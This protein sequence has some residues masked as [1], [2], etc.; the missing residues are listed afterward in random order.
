VRG[1]V[2][3]LLPKPVSGAI[4]PGIAPGKVPKADPNPGAGEGLVVA[5]RTT[6]GFVPKRGPDMNLESGAGGGA[7]VLGSAF[8]MRLNVPGFI[9]G[10]NKLGALVVGFV[11]SSENPPKSSVGTGTLVTAGVGKEDEGLSLGAVLF[12]KG[13]GGVFGVAV[14]DE[15]GA[16][17]S[18]STKGSTLAGGGVNLASAGDGEVTLEAVSHCPNGIFGDAGRGLS[19]EPLTSSSSPPDTGVFARGELRSG[20]VLGLPR[21]VLE[22]GDGVSDGEGSVGIGCCNDNG[23][24]DGDPGGVVLRRRTVDGS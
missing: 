17:K 20:R 23:S 1:G 3:D 16:L 13:T 5:P 12:A 8:G 14:T 22:A 2:T 7:S 10:P 21:L 24:L 15:A 6:G 18:W 4:A 11:A 9:P 19:E